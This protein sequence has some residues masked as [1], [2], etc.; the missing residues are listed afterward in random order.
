V[1]LIQCGVLGFMGLLSGSQCKEGVCFIATLEPYCMLLYETLP[2]NF[3]SPYLAQH[4]IETIINIEHVFNALF[5]TC[6]TF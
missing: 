1:A 2:C 5:L 4:V 6:R 3:L